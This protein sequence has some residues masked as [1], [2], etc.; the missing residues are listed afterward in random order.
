[1]N[2]PSEDIKDILLESDAGLDLVFGT[3]LFYSKEPDSGVV[4]K[5]VTIY[6]TG[7]DEPAANYTYEFPN[8][9]VKIRGDVLKYK[10]AYSLLNDI[11]N[12]LHG[13]HNKTINGARYV[14]IWA[15]S[16]IISLGYDE[17]NR[18]ELTINFRMQR[19]TA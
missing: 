14:G 1:M 2:S 12:E 3:S 10:E 17:E 8:I 11:K 19:T 13:T 18:P 15:S 16:D 5:I 4:D 9:Q 7:G 6:D